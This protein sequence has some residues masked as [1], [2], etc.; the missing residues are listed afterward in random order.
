M[1]VMK[2]R[3]KKCGG[4]AM[5]IAKLESFS[6]PDVG[7]IKITTLC[8]ATGI[9]QMSTYHADITAQIFHRQV[10]PWVLGREL[11]LDNLYTEALDIAALV[12]ERE[13]KYPGS[14][15]RR[16]MAGLDTALWDLAGKQAGLPVARLIGGT[17]GQLRAYASSMRRDI[18]PVDEA[19]RLCDLRDRY[20][21]DAFKFRIGAECGR[22]E[23]EWPGRSEDIMKTVSHALGDD[24]VRMV[25]ANSCWGAA[26]AIEIGHM[27]VDNGIT[28]YE[29]PCPYWKPD[30]T[31]A[32]TAALAP[33]DIEVTGGE[34]DCDLRHWHDMMNRHVVD[35]LQPDVMYMG[36]LTPTLHLAKIAAEQGYVVTPH[37]ANL[38]LVTMCTMHL[39]LAINNAGPYL[40]YAIEGADYYPWTQDLFEN[41][42]FAVHDGKVTI[43]E[44]PG[45]GVTVNPAFF[46]N[47]AYAVSELD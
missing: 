3:I 16:A 26:R 11:D 10:A 43:T 2:M 36:G 30:A 44:E 22:G 39:L 27:L 9:G 40:E 45:W 20:G 41:D 12:H 1:V 6:T 38:S 24:V 32:V 35:V 23:D 25:D 18:T 34:Q 46:D 42:P 37:A 8:G 33:L 15:V 28:H 5:K 7:F 31:R 21:F 17:T 4:R 13:H 29:E 14:Y 19:A 47:A